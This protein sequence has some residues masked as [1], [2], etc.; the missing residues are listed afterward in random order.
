MFPRNKDFN[1]TKR[2]WHTVR[3]VGVGLIARRTS[4][5]P[6]HVFRGLDSTPPVHERTLADDTPIV[7]V[8]HGLTGGQETFSFVLVTSSLTTFNV[9]VV[10]DLMNHMY[11]PSS[12]KPSNPL[13]MAVLVI[14]P[15]SSI[16]EGVRL[17]RPLM[18]SLQTSHMPF[19]CGGHFNERATLLC[20]TYG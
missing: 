14:V 1:S 19:R 17:W 10:Q 13:Q 4:A 15:S 3:V 2:W 8:K 9:F 16:S 12:R 11:A 6:S 20:R 7:V 18:S 5:E